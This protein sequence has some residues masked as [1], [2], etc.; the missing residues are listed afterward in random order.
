M[1]RVERLA[2]WWWQLVQVKCLAA[3]LRWQLLGKKELNPWVLLCQMDNRWGLGVGNNN[4]D[5]LAW[6]VKND[7]LARNWILL[8]SPVP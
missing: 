2:W 7:Q 8:D 1:L 5:F 6:V 3:L 4:G